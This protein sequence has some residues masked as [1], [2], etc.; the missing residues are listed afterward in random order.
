MEIKLEDLKRSDIRI[1]SYVDYTVS[2]NKEFV[3]KNKKYGQTWLCYRPKSI[4]TRF[5]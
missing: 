3:E 1:A 2:C 5:W 4:L